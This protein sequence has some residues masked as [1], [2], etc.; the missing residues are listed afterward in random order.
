MRAVGM[1]VGGIVWCMLIFSFTLWL[2]FPSDTLIERIRH[3]TPRMM[4]SEYSSD[5]ASI[6]PWW[7]GVAAKDVKLYSTATQ[8]WRSSE[9]PEGPSL[10]GIAKDVRVRA[11]PFSMLRN[12]PYVSGSVTL[13][14]A[15]VTY[16]LGFAEN[17][18]GAMGL[19]SAD[20]EGSSVPLA[21]LLMLA[22]STAISATGSVDA[23]LRF[24][25]GE[26]GLSTA[27][28][29]MEIS[30]EN[31]VLSDIEI[32]GIGPLGMD[33]PIESLE[34]TCPVREG[35]C[36][37]ERGTVS[38]PLLDMRIEGHVA[39]RDPLSRSTL[40]IELIV[41]DLGDD[42]KAFEGFMSSA[43]QSDGAY[44]Y[45]CRGIV[46]RLRSCQPVRA[47]ARRSTTPRPSPSR[48]SRGTANRGEPRSASS[49]NMD[50]ER[51][52]RR[53]EI[54]ERLRQRREARERDREDDVEEEEEI[55]EDELDEEILEDE[56][57]DEEEGEEFEEE[58]ED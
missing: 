40:D 10:V 41:S 15:P 31:I 49:G 27:E 29:K 7:F 19:V 46:S 18:R 51:E 21:D 25:A 24:E 12:K 22:P 1:V 48:T 8:D 5:L 54:R 37:I 2:T 3:E 43:K 11:S 4:G 20:V 36:E 17:E 56:F 38:S 13:T 47:S 44:H 52:R 6:A 14:E 26:D 28:G 50:E 58:F 16:A 34:L 57:I 42:L 55:P 33:I 45:A 30:G 32:P 35:K 23:E 39:L 9:E 53:Q